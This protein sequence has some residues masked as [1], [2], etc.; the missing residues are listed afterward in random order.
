MCVERRGRMSGSHAVR[1]VF[2][3]ASSC[4]PNWRPT[5]VR[6]QAKNRMMT[7]KLK[8]STVPRVLM[9]RASGVASSSSCSSAAA[10]PASLLSASPRSALNCARSLSR[11]DSLARSPESLRSTKPAASSPYFARTRRALLVTYGLVSGVTK[12][13]SRLGSASAGGGDSGGGG[14]GGGGGGGGGEE[15]ALTVAG[16]CTEKLWPGATP[17]GTTTW[18]WAP[19]GG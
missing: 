19:R 10:P 9:T 6:N 8:V 3:T 17:S 12:L 4:A 14:S 13:P 5:P 15:T 11:R 1:N 18:H 16:S 2:I 7:K